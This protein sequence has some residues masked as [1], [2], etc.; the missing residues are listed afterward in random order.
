MYKI[1]MTV[2]NSLYYLT[3]LLSLI[4][5]EIK[6]RHFVFVYSCT[7]NRVIFKTSIGKKKQ[8]DFSFS[9]T[10]R[11]QRK[12][13]AVIGLV[14]DPFPSMNVSQSRIKCVN[15]REWHRIEQ[16]SYVII[17]RY[18]TSNN[19]QNNRYSLASSENKRKR[20]WRQE[21]REAEN[22]NDIEN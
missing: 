14:S 21:T 20:D 16:K 11:G 10:G 15:G 18:G 17:T 5:E 22:I 7:E 12:A 19:V 13:D 3:N 9:L 4:I 2:M 6:F 1:R 8:V